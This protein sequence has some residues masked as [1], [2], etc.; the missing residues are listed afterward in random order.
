MIWECTACHP[1]RPC[2]A[3]NGIST[4]PQVCLLDPKYTEHDWHK[5]HSWKA[6]RRKLR[7]TSLLSVKD[8]AKSS[9]VCPDSWS[10]LCFVDPKIDKEADE[11]ARKVELAVLGMQ[12]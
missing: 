2:R 4:A 1:Q 7:S 11:L 12:A 10:K 6:T 3:E 5:A 8:I 9:R